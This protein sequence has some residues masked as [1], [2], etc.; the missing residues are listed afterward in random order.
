MMNIYLEIARRFNVQFRDCLPYII[1][2]TRNDFAKFL[3]DFAFNKGAE[4]GVRRGDY[5]EVLLRMNKDLNLMSI[6][7]WFR[8][9]HHLVAAGRKLEPY[10]ER[11]KMWRIKS[12]DAARE[13][14]DESLDFVYIDA[15]HDFDN[16]M[17]DIITWSKK[18]R[19]G[20]IVAGHDYMSYPDFGVIEAVNAYTKWHNIRQWWIT[21]EKIATV[22]PSWFWV[23]E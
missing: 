23:K 10:K 15:L 17:V 11:V 14:A 9:G 1:H 18:V 21:E 5:S 22:F 13:V 3:G 19:K 20:G 8:S 16:A 6:D 7:P 4:I 12:L 2:G